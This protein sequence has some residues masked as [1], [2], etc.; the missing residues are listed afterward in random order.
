MPF[1]QASLLEYLPALNYYLR[2]NGIL[3][4]NIIKQN[5]NKLTSFPLA[6]GEVIHPFVLNSLQSRAWSYFMDKAG[7]IHKDNT[8]VQFLLHL[9]EYILDIVN[10]KSTAECG[11][12]DYNKVKN[13]VYGF[14]NNDFG[15]ANQ[16]DWWLS[17][18]LFR[19]GTK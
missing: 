1:A 5:N 4:R 13:I 8:N 2:K 18:E 10:S 11:F 16:L 3:F 6:K 19:Q 7:L 15:L 17:F 12:Y 9:K 14:Y